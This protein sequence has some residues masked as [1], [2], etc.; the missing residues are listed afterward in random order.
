M[1]LESITGDKAK[2]EQILNIINY[3]SRDFDRAIEGASESTVERERYK[4]LE[5]MSQELEDMGID[6]ENPMRKF[7]FTKLDQAL[8]RIINLHDGADISAMEG[9]YKNDAQRKAVHAAKNES[10]VS[11]T[12]I[13]QSDPLTVLGNIAQRTDGKPFPVKMYNGTTIEVSPAVARRFITAYLNIEDPDQ[14]HRVDTYLK[15]VNGFKELMQK[16]ESVE[17]D[18][19]LLAEAWL[20]EDWRQGF[21]DWMRNNVEEPT[22]DWLNSVGTDSNTFMNRNVR[23]PMG[24]MKPG[25]NRGEDNYNGPDANVV[26]PAR[27]EPTAASPENLPKIKDIDPATTGNYAPGKTST[28]SID[29]LRARLQQQRA[30]SSAAA[31]DS[32]DAARTQRAQDF[33]QELRRSVR[34]PRR[35]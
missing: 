6:K 2:H 22:V 27:P 12:G 14:K 17:M 35:N 3:V 7:A 26:R 28:S 21:K 10:K 5:A 15:T 19:D 33:R 9:K 4:A 29:A 32:V 30:S 8:V 31:A 16:V 13:K 34:A 25:Y 20:N 11:K 1:R 23:V 24:L 18:D